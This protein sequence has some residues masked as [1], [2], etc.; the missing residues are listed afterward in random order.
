MPIKY[1]DYNIYVAL[2]QRTMQ[3]GRHG[4]IQFK[5]TSVFTYIS[6]LPYEAGN[7]QEGLSNY[8]IHV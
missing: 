5:T 3:A 4:S 2:V 1:H 8:K 6:M 7:T